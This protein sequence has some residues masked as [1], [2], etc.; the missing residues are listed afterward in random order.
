MPTLLAA[1]GA[2]GSPDHPFDGKDMWGA[3]AEGKPSPHEDLLI[4]A[5]IFRGAVRKGQWKLVKTALLPG[6][7]EL[8][9]LSK[10]IGEKNNVAEQFPDVVRDLEARLVQYAREA[11]TSE[12]LKAQPGFFGRR[13]RPRSTPTS[14]STT[15]GCRR[16]SRCCRRR[17]RG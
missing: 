16:R 12:W 10:D 9:D 14:T 5:E 7:T 3:I 8:F 17:R 15:A 4:N 13:A 2:K 11:K 6:K 1:A